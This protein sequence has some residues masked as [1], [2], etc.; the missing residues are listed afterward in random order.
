MTDVNLPRRRFLQILLVS[1]STAA[2]AACGGGSG[3]SVDVVGPPGPTTPPP[4]LP[5]EPE[6]LAME[7]PLSAGPLIDIGQLQDS[8]VDGILIPEG[9]RIRRVAISGL[10]ADTSLPLPSLGIINYPWHIFPDG[11]AVFDLD[12][13]G[14]IY[15]SNSEIAPGG[16]VGVLKFNSESQITDSYQILRGTR[17]NCAGGPTPW[18]T[19][20]SCEEVT[21][22]KVF[23]C[24]P[25]GTPDTAQELPALGIFNHEAVAVD[26][27]T[28]TL[29][30]TEDAGDGRLYR[31][32]SSGMATSING[33]QG[34]DMQNGVLEVLEIE[35]FEAGG[36]QEDIAQARTVKRVTWVPVISPERAQSRVRSEIQ[37]ATGQAAP[38]T[39]F[40]GGEGIWLQEL[41]PSEQV[42]V[43][44]APNPLRAV[45]Y[46]ACKGDNRVYALDI[47]NDLI[48]VVFDNE[49]LMAPDIPF[50][51]VDN[52]TVSP[53]NDI[54][55]AEDGEAMR[56]MVMNP[57]GPSK[58]L[59]Q[60]PG[61][62]SELTG[63]AFTSSG[64]FLYFSNQRGSALGPGIP[65]LG[66]TYEL[67][68]PDQ[69]LA[70]N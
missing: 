62:G 8:G 61:G 33:R 37:D 66:T 64:K 68:I 5:P 41:A 53:M 38:G 69:Y 29:Y 17:R 32:R 34:L 4:G 56:L 49:Q 40:R 52:L 9:F 1:G 16:G 30:L 15:V 47:D 67:E 20:L 63:P 21:D 35:G 54:I 51:D 44:G 10:T 28:R 24:D 27:K 45:I 12:D 23:E 22:G 43:E 14:W 7:L 13:G 6:T 3:S 11:G 59:L 26:M 39:I 57:N 36:Y 25:L 31:F 48:E 42:A 65:G 50:D 46:F 55:V 19:W 58:I 2:L 70:A 60:I 18:Q